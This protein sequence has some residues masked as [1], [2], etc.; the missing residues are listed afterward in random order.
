MSLALNELR[1]K[2]R[3]YGGFKL[4]GNRPGS[5][6]G[7]VARREIP[8][9]DFFQGLIARSFDQHDQLMDRQAWM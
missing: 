9:S 7:D 1:E 5:S 8:E 2:A 4:A 3:R 6:R